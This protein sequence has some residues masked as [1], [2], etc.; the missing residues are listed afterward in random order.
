L[1]SLEPKVKK[2]CPQVILE[3]SETEYLNDS[4]YRQHSETISDGNESNNKTFADTFENY[5]SPDFNSY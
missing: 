1:L 2:S 5:L 3:H 4:D